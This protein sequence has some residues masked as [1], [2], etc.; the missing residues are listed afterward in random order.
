MKNMVIILFSVFWMMFLPNLV[1][2]N[3]NQSDGAASGSNFAE[4]LSVA[5]I[6]ANG[7]V[8]SYLAGGTQI[9]EHGVV[10]GK[11]PQPALGSTNRAACYMGAAKNVPATKTF[12]KV[13]ASRLDPGTKY[14][15]RAYVKESS[16]NIV[17][18]NEVNFTTPKL[19]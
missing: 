13:T 2:S 6:T 4:G 10:Y 14:Y 3:G 9:T 11:S 8:F 12:F 16:G 17:Y 5:G 19:K 18:S 15:A 1:F 7:A